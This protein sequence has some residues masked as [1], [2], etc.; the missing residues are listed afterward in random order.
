MRIKLGVPEYAIKTEY[1][2]VSDVLNEQKQFPVLTI[3]R[4]SYIEQA[5]VETVLDT[6]L[7]YNLQVG[8]YTSIA[9]DVTFVVDMNHD[10]RRPCQGRISGVNY[11]RPDRTKRK[12]Q[13][14]IM[15]DCWIGEK[16]T[17]MSGVTVGNGA[18]VAAE[19]VVTKDVP[20]Y[21]IAAGNPARVIG[22]RFS[23]EQ[24]EN[25]LLIKWWNWDEGKVLDA[26]K[27]L[28]GDIDEF[29]SKYIAQAR[30]DYEHIKFVDIVSIEKFNSGEEKRLL[31]VPDFEQDYP[32]YPRVVDAF[33]KSFA[34][35]NT[36]LLLYVTEDEY[37]QDKLDALNE[38]F[39]LYENVNCYVN[40]YV[41]NL[42]DV[43]G[44]F[45]Q[46]DGYITNRS[47]ENVHYVDV[48]RSYQLDVI[49]GVDIPIFGEKKVENLVKNVDGAGQKVQQVADFSQEKLMDMV[50]KLVGTIKNQNQHIEQL[51]SKLLMMDKAIGQ[52]SVNQYA[53]NNSIDNLKYELLCQDER[54][55]YPIVESGDKAIDL[56]LDQRKSMCRLGDGEFAVI[57]GVNRQKFQRADSRLGERL[58]EIL[59]AKDENVL[60]CIADTYG[61]LSKY[62]TDCKYNIRAYMTEEVRKQHYDLLD[63]QK[64]YYDTYVTRPYA[65]Y[66][67]NNTDAPKKR[68]DKLRKIWQDKKLLIIEGEKTRMGVGNDLFDNASDIIRILGPAEHAFDKYD[69]LL[70]EALK[71]DR[72]R[73]VLIA[74][75][76]TAT[77]LA[78][79][80]SKAGF[81][82]LDIGH[83]DMEYEWMLAGTGKK[84]EVRHKYNNE[85]PGGDKVEEIID[86]VY[87]SQIVARIY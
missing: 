58:K 40:L 83:I 21:A 25:L 22:Y 29:I 36:E 67:D 8:G 24:I 60:V 84:V 34:D 16:A 4:D 52:I 82:A 55:K 43:R 28:Y 20:D 11:N 65:S 13:I 85:V 9:P 45:S 72:D 33:A 80:L 32:T 61:D 17:I 3:G 70:A 6:D 18:V 35:T 49:S 27:E 59:K 10:Y 62:N 41:G 76:A 30:E 68:F 74:M 39:A 75:G 66:L 42:E 14:I 79:D 23:K 69:E 1:S 46:V 12:G 54:P 64:I 56:I 47:K 19:A 31:Y 2:Y 51:E 81:Q 5:I 78:Y 71:Q 53:M 87:E 50:S 63:F 77:V 44:L 73:L 38:V 48:A 57:A 26:G 7:V 37:L 86:P 15:N